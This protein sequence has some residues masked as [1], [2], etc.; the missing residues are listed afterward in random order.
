LELPTVD[1][2]PSILIDWVPACAVTL[3][4]PSSLIERAQRRIWFGSAVLPTESPKQF[5]RFFCASNM[6]AKALHTKQCI[7]QRITNVAVDVFVTVVTSFLLAATLLKEQRPIAA[8]H[9]SSRA[10][11]GSCLPFKRHGCNGG[12]IQTMSCVTRPCRIYA[13]R[14]AVRRRRRCLV[15]RRG[16]TR[17]AAVAIPS[18][19]TAFPQLDT[20]H[21]QVD[22]STKAIIEPTV[23][24][25]SF[26]V[27]ITIRC[28][29][30]THA[31]THTGGNFVV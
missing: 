19:V 17:E 14:T 2:T 13:Q 31:R 22:L 25:V 5:V 21:H 15:L 4:Q 1:L 24:S 3:L 23:L 10:N 16:P 28:A 8:L 18:I 20:D 27:A 29:G 7:E 30:R 26:L 6:R 9:G 11:R 12:G